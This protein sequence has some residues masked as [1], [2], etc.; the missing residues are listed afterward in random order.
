M[1]LEEGAHPVDRPLFQL[2]GL[3]PREDRDL[4]GRRQRGDIDRGLERVCRR[5][6]GQ[7]EDWGATVADEIARHAVQ[8]IGPDAIEIVKIL[9]DSFHR[10]V[11]PTGAEIRDPNLVPVP[12]HDIRVLG[13]VPDALAKHSSDDTLGRA[14]EE[15][16]GKTAADAVTHIEE[17][18]DAEVVRQPQL[19][20]GERVPR[21]AGRDRA[22]GLAAT[23][24]A[25]VHRDAAEVPLERLRR[26]KH[27]GG[28]IADPGVQAP[29]GGDQQWEAGADLLIADADVAFLVKRHGFLLA[30]YGHAYARLKPLTRHPRVIPGS[31]PGRGPGAAAPWLP[32]D[33]R[34]RGNDEPR[35]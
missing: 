3:A 30:R 35:L 26:V 20:V 23:R 12:V 29:A 31:S 25:L 4:G 27:R 7:H 2:R 34:F 17:F 14:F 19:V 33:S 13:P 28:P 16:P 5:V 21:V 18:A 6:V 24:V 10:H 22:G 11:G 32:L 8:E 9:L 15:L 1:R